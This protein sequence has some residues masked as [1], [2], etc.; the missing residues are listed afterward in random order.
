MVLDLL[1]ETILRHVFFLPQ[2]VAE[3]FVYWQTL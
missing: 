1:A 2:S 3:S